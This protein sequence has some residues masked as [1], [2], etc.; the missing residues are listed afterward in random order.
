MTTQGAS[1]DLTAPQT[2][3]L[4]HVRRHTEQTRFSQVTAGSWVMR[5]EGPA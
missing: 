4:D 1:T 3:V 5:R 2:W